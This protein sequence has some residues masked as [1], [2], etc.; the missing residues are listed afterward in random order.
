[1]HSIRLTIATLLCL[2]PRAVVRAE[3]PEAALLTRPEA[4]G[5]R[6]TTSYD[7]TI[8]LLR[9]L[10]GALSP[11]EARLLRRVGTGTTACRS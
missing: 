4:S 6:A 7:E 10:Q 11:R 8:E 2:V 5:F 3:V 9:R 1:M